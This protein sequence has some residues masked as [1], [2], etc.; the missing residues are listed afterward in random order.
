MNK[1]YH[2]VVLAGLL[3]DIGKFLQR[4][5]F[6]QGIKISGKHPA[7]SADLIRVRKDLFAEVADVPLLIE[8]VQRHHESRDFPP[9]L[10]VQEAPP[11]VRPLAYLVSTADNYSSAERG[12][13]ARRGKDFRTIPLASV[14]SRLKLTRETPEP[15]YY[16]LHP[17]DPAL[18]FPEDFDMLDPGQTAAYLRSFGHEF[19]A[20]LSRTNISDF[21][22]VFTHLLSLFERYTWCL[23]SNTLDEFPDISLFDHLRTTAAIAACLYQYHDKTT[24]FTIKQITNSD[25][26]KFRLVVGDLSGIQNYIF[27]I[28]GIGAGGVAKRLR[29]RSFYLSALL[30][31]ISHRILHEFDLPLCNI[32]FSSGGKFYLLLPNINGSKEKIDNLQVELDRWFLEQ[33]HGELT[34]NLAQLPFSGR[35]FACFGQVM[36]SVAEKL[37][38][39]KVMPLKDYLVKNGYWQSELFMSG[40]GKW[41]GGICPGCRKNPV[42]QAGDGE[43]QF[44]PQCRRDLEM[45]T[46]LANAGYIAFSKEP[47]SSGCF[48]GVYPLHGTYNLFIS[49]DKPEDILPFYLVVRLNNSN[50]NE[51]GKYPTIFKYMTNYIPLADENPCYEC[52]G[53]RDDRKPGPGEPLYFDCLANRSR[54]RKLL[55][56]LKADVDNLGSLF[57]YGLRGETNDNTSISRLA[58]M[59]RMLDLFF[60]GRME[61]LLKTKFTSCYTVFSGGDD[62][63]IIGPWDE[64]ARLAVTVQTEFHHFTCRNPNITL[65][66]G[67]ALVKPRIP[68]SRGVAVA[69]EMLEESKEKALPGYQEGRDQLSF[70]GTT[71]HW[72]KVERLFQEAERLASWLKQE[73][74]STGFV[75]KLLYFATLYE[76]YHFKGDVAGLRYLPLLTYEIAR[77]LGIPQD[78]PESGVIRM[79]VEK[80]KEV[81]H[82]YI[83]N[84]KLLAS[85]ALLTLDVRSDST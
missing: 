52:K 6:Q 31:S 26:L 80:L 36:A 35:D 73:R 41:Q 38:D 22:C 81:G 54:G 83:V 53:C 13:T 71:V 11:E 63:F 79:W 69:E 59:S 42:G 75:R 44:C 18:A 85:Y 27:E 50:I 34:I 2:T 46:R 76:K 61:Q 47:I 49:R 68:L 8:L 51:S 24:S 9:E 64:I 28:S 32:I 70:L 57:V 43:Q 10:R 40:V 45:G 56:Y 66:A 39:K 72:S 15:L 1:Q 33:F 23:P 25:E 60:A 21:N 67:I 30:E 29:A 65:S 3:H 19:D 48:A 16:R 55:G 77:N 82:D 14:F 74:L 17:L 58:T 5:D 20:L 7:I 4:G 84:L 62:L 78:D 37:N 12:E